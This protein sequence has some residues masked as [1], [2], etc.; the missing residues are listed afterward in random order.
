MGAEA[1]AV[2]FAVLPDLAF[3][4]SSW[5]HSMEQVG[6]IAIRPDLAG[7]GF[8]QLRQPGTRPMGEYTP[9]A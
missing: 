2:A 1:A 8:L 7:S 4:L 3:A 5:L 9:P 6:T